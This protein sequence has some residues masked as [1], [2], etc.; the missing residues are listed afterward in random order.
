[1]SKNKQSKIMLM[2]LQKLILHTIF[3]NYYKIQLTQKKIQK[4]IPLRYI[5]FL[6]QM[7][8]L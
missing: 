2:K 8:F 6:T 4:L 1:M 5:L 3:Q 7:S